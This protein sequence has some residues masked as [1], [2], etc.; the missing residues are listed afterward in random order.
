MFEG[1]G[2]GF[3]FLGG[4]WRQ[5]NCCALGWEGFLSSKEQDF[6]VWDDTCQWM[7]MV[8]KESLIQSI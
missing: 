2:L 1:L 7:K 6:D 5:G 3:G 8:N 4:S